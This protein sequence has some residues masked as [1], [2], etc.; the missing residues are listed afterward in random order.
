MGNYIL[1]EF[2]MCGEMI[3]SG[4]EPG[5]MAGKKVVVVVVVVVVKLFS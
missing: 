3:S 5:V 2:L 1:C 4:M